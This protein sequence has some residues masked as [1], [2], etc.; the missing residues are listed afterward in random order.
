MGHEIRRKFL[1]ENKCGKY[2]RRYRVFKKEPDPLNVGSLSSRSWSR[3]PV[4]LHRQTYNLHL[5]H[6]WITIINY[7]WDT[8]YRFKNISPCI[9][10]FSKTYKLMNQACAFLEFKN[11]IMYLLHKF[12]ADM[13]NKHE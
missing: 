6:L 9:L 7:E 2:F 4:T 12:V 10:V 1:Y 13:K 5:H 11:Y 3:S 8:L